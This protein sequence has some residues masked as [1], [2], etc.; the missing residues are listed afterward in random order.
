M[1]AHSFVNSF[2]LP[3]Y[4]LFIVIFEEKLLFMIK[5]GTIIRDTEVTFRKERILL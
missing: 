2:L 3:F 1:N 5:S 4:E